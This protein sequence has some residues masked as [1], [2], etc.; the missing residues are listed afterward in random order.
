MSRGP[1]RIERAIRELLDAHP[2]LVFVTDEL[3]EHCYPGITTIERKHQVS[4][5]RAAH[6]AIANDRDWRAWGMPI[7]QGHGLVLMNCG[8]LKSY[9]MGRGL[10]IGHVSPKRA[11]RAA[12]VYRRITVKEP[13]PLVD[14]ESVM[15]GYN[16]RTRQWLARGRAQDELN[17][18]E[19]DA[20]WS[21]EVQLHCARRDGFNVLADS[22]RD[23]LNAGFYAGIPK[24]CHTDAG[25]GKETLNPDPPEPGKPV[26]RE[27][28]FLAMIADRIRGL[29]AQNDPDVL[30]ASLADVAAELDAWR[31]AVA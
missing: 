18:I 16:E 12:R 21:R 28:R 29:T 10:C 4:V 23:R 15:P 8:N 2:D 26:L 24:R 6:N 7:A 17:R 9:L 30:R 20:R 14:L 11:A 5:L 22:L 3:V 13:R 1:G 19:R 25:D 31:E 27:D